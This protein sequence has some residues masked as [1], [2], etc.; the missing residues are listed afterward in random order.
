MWWV[1]L[2]SWFCGC[3]K[4][5]EHVNTVAYYSLSWFLVLFPV[6]GKERLN[7]SSFF[8]NCLRRK[9]T[10]RRQKKKII[11]VKRRNFF[12]EILTSGVFCGQLVTLVTPS[13]IT[14]LVFLVLWSNLPYIIK[15]RWLKNP[16]FWVNDINFAGDLVHSPLMYKVTGDP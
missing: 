14:L 7:S 15:S 5:T 3:K 11:K 12:L 10:F 16:H 13:L 1:C 8:S 2:F 6:R 4:K 9:V